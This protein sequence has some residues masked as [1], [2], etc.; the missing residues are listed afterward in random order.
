MKITDN[1]YQKEWWYG[2][3]NGSFHES[4]FYGSINTSQKWVHYKV[5]IEGSTMSVEATYGDT[6]VA[7]HTET[8]HFTRGSSTKYGF[9]SEWATNKVTRYKNIVAYKI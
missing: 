1:I 7:T 5:T 2:Y 9:N 4:K 3:N 8:I 6:T